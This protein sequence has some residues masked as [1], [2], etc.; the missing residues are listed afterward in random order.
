MIWNEGGGYDVSSAKFVFPRSGV[1]L[2]TFF[3]GVISHN[4]G[5]FVVSLMISHVT[6]FSAGLGSLSNIQS[7]QAIVFDYM[8]RNEG[9]GYEVNSAKFVFPRSGVY[10]FTFF[11]GVR[12]YNQG[13]FVVSLMINGRRMIEAQTEVEHRQQDSQGGS[14]VVVK[15][16]KYDKM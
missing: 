13:Q 10:L 12:H 14:S 6:A 8:I 11:I 16:D 4:Q 5:Q 7:R 15:L 9:G 2:F 1:Y 3:I